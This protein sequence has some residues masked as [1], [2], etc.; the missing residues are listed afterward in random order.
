M[1]GIRRRHLYSYCLRSRQGIPY[2]DGRD[3]DSDD[4][5]QQQV[6]QLGQ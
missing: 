2:C 3:L 5:H 6:Q 4:W 1:S